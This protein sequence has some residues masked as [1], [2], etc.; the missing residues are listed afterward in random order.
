MTYLL[1]AYMLPLVIVSPIS[2]VF[3]DR[4]RVKQVMIS[5]DLTY[6]VL[7]LL[8]FSVATRV[9]IATDCAGPKKLETRASTTRIAHNYGRLVTELRAAIALVSQAFYTVCLLSPIVGGALVAW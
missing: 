5:S 4:W 8:L 9:R 1:I 2:G 6:G 7:V 3:V